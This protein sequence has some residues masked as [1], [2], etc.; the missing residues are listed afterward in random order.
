MRQVRSTTTAITVLCL[1]IPGS[2]ANNLADFLAKHR[3]AIQNYI[4][5]GYGDGW[6]ECDMLSLPPVQFVPPLSV[7]QY[8]VDIDG[9]KLID[10]KKSM[11][12]AYCLLVAARVTGGHFK[13][14]F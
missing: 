5:T 7:P 8:V 2:S 10:I 12:K 13:R 3:V 4:M 1:S 6:K 14:I 11:T 9:L